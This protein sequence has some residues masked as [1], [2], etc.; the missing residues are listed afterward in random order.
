MLELI[1][2]FFRRCTT[3]KNPILYWGLSVEARRRS[4]QP[5]ASRIL[6][7]ELYKRKAFCSLRSQ[8]SFSLNDL[9]SK[10]EAM[11]EK[12]PSDF[13]CGLSFVARGRIELPTS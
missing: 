10:L 2:R 7:G 13:V 3:Q 9:S 8:W 12:S 11:N 1:G 5:S 4:A 6:Q